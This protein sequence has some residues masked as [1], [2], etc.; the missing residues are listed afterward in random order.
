MKNGNKQLQLL[1]AEEVKQINGGS[2]DNSAGMTLSSSANSLLS[3]E[4][5]WQQG[6]NYRDYKLDVGKN[7]NINLGVFGIAQ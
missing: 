3:I 1:N 6:D 5:K 2:A 4:F 7:V